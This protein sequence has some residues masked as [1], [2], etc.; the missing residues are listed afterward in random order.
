MMVQIS[1]FSLAGP[2]F[3]GQRFWQGREA[4]RLTIFEALVNTPDPL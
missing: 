3:F 1:V 4:K 2:S